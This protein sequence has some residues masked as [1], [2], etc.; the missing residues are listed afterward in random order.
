MPVVFV[1]VSAGSS[2]NPCSLPDVSALGLDL[3]P[4]PASASRSSELIDPRPNMLIGRGFTAAFLAEAPRWTA[5]ETVPLGRRRLRRLL[6]VDVNTGSPDGGSSCAMLL[7][8]LSRE[9]VVCRRRGWVTVSGK[10]IVISS[11]RRAP[12]MRGWD[13]IVLRCADC[14]PQLENRCEVIEDNTETQP[15]RDQ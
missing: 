11:T 10:L 13:G 15:T 5:A 4:V 14:S 9:Q 2:S 12:K 1:A 6:A 3:E 8:V 7:G